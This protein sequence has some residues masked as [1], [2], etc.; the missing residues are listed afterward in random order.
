MDARGRTSKME[1]KAKR[2]K[3]STPAVTSAEG[4]SQYEVGTLLGQGAFASVRRATDK[5][6][7][8]GVAIKE[9]FREKTGS[10]TAAPL[11]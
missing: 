10:A 3:R 7:G 4:L 11:S 1:P 2:A 5:S 6:T 9:V 8:K